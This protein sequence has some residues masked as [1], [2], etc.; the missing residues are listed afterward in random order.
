LKKLLLSLLGT[1]ALYRFFRAAWVDSMDFTVYWRAAQA[2]I[3]G[4][5]SP[6]FYD[7]TTR[8]FVFKYPPWILPFFLPFGFLSFETSK[9]AWALVE[10]ACLGYAVLW[11]K[12]AGASWVILLA[13]LAMF[14]WIWLAHF[15]AGQFT[16]VL[17]AFSLWAIPPRGEQACA[18]PLRL[19][20]LAFFMTSKVFSLVTL[21]GAWRCYLKLRTTA[22]LAMLLAAA[23]LIL[24]MK[25]QLLGGDSL[26]SLYQ[27][28]V[29]AAGSG[30][31]GLGA[32]VVRGQMNHGFTA[33]VL[34]ALQ[35]PSE[36]TRADLITASALALLLSALWAYVSRHLPLQ[37]RWAG[38]LGVGLVSH[39]L[40][41][42]HSFVLAFPICALAM[43][44]AYDAGRKPLIALSVLATCMIGI[45]LPEVLGPALVTPLELV[46]SKSWGVCIAA[47]VL[48]RSRAEK[49]DR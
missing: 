43:A 25:S 23:N 26:L 21:L 47:A 10:L 11:L 31:Q 24:L 35:I 30:G 34:R 9:I 42:H 7:Q 49:A 36:N 33:G 29:G 46:S 18:K 1:Y 22:A 17:L 38:W 32:I 8:G 2:W 3:H 37:E 6:Y 40:A 14:W 15:F 45:L 20:A 28:W 16:L 41:W 12:R 5:V 4:G 48:V 19:G 13:T 27:G 39:P 44:R